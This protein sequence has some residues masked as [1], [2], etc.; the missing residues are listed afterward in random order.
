MTIATDDVLAV[1]LE[2]RDYRETATRLGLQ[3]DAVRKR[4]K[5]NLPAGSSTLVEGSGPIKLQWLRTP[6]EAL[7]GEEVASQVTDALKGF[8]PPAPLKTALKGDKDLL[9]IWPL[10]DLHMGMRAWGAET[11]GPDWDIKIA[12]QAYQEGL[13][14]VTAMTPKVKLGVV[15]VAGDLS[16]ADNYHQTTTNPATHHIV[17]VDGRYPKMLE[18]S[19]DI[20]LYAVQ[21]AKERAE[22]VLVVILPGN[23]DGGTAV[24][25]RLAVS[26]YFR[27]DSSVTV[28]KSPSPFWWYEWGKCMFACTHGDKLRMRKLPGYMADQMSEMWGRTKYR[29]AFTGHFHQKLVESHPGVTV[30]ILPTP[31]APDS[32]SSSFG[33]KAPRMFETKLYHKERG[34]RHTPTVIL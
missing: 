16:H 9:G 17:D 4:V 14:E 6:R 21:R 7:S 23:H 24:G 10:A 31:V 34:L 12:T 18:A 27:N 32:F 29:Y 3:Y 8:K 5:R 13:S 26:M 28:D 33:Y 22:K 15:L 30:E 25:V 20:V 11:G 2:T 19:V 1:F